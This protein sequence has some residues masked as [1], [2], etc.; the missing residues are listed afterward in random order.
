VT[1]GNKQARYPRDGRLVRIF[2]VRRKRETLCCKA[3]LEHNFY[4]VL[5]V[6]SKNVVVI[7]CT[8]VNHNARLYIEGDLDSFGRRSNCCDAV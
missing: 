6:L 4:C 3:Y 2:G 5:Y 7:D 8:N 1:V